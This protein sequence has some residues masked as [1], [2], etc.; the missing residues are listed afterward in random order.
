[1]LISNAYATDHLDDIEEELV[2]EE[3]DG[4]KDFETMQFLGAGN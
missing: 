2:I 3:E 1:M 4:S